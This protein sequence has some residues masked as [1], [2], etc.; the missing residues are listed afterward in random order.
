DLEE[1]GDEILSR[2]ESAMRRA[3]A[4]IPD[5]TYSQTCEVD[6]F[7]EV[8]VRIKVA[9]TIDGDAA[10]VDFAG[11]S[12]QSERGWNVVLNYAAAYTHYAL[13][14]ALAPDVPHNDG[15]FRPISVVAPEGTLFN[16]R[17]PAA[18]AARQIAGHFIPHV[19][20]GALRDVLEDR[21]VAE[22]AGGLWVTTLRGLGRDRFVGIC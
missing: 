7:G 4:S 17:Y 8:P 19:V 22:G 20:F 13:K 6:G 12:E 11:S 3:L 15:S 14:C 9:V 18:V 10:T 1:V 16:P 2:S 21:V 5:G